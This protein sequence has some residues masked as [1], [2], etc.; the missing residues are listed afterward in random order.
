MMTTQEPIQPSGLCEC[1][2]G[3]PTLPYRRYLRGH[4][5]RYAAMWRGPGPTLSPDDLRICK[6]CGETKPVSEYHRAP[7]SRDRFCSFCKACKNEKMARY[8][9]KSDVPGAYQRIHRKKIRDLCLSHYSN[10]TYRCAC[11][12]ES[13][14]EFLAIDHMNGNGQEH[15]RE[16]GSKGGT[17]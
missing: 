9:A 6:G 17:S 8:R 15:R 2:C 5:A 7:E 13:A 14:Y 12:G 10:G 3:S 16:I 1:G 4:N 11:C